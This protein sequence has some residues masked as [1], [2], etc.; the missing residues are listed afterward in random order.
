[1]SPPTSS[2]WEFG[3]FECYTYQNIEERHFRGEFVYYKLPFI[4]YMFIP[5]ILSRFKVLRF[6]DMILRTKDKNVALS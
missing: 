1:M 4:V 5:Y 3:Q 2:K 6:Y